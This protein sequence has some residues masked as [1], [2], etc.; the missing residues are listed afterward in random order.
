MNATI[1]GDFDSYDFIHELEAYIDEW[2]ASSGGHDVT[3]T[4][5]GNNSINLV[6]GEEYYYDLI[7][8]IRFDFRRLIRNLFIDEE[9]Y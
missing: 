6:M 7:D 3:L 1:R 8:D 9:E 2:F 5:G 4:I